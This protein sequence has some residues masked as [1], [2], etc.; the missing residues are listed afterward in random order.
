MNYRSVA[1]LNAEARR[2]AH[3]LPKDIDLV[4]GIPRSGLLAAN[5]L[6][7]HLD[8]P[9]TD[10]DGLVEGRILK[11]GYRFEAG[12]RLADVDRVLV[13]DDSVASG[14][15]MRDTKGRIRDEDLPYDIEYAAIYISPE[16]YQHVDHW[17]AVV[18]RKRVFE[19]NLMHH[20]LLQNFCVDIDGVLCRDPTDEEND[21]G[22][23]YR[24]FVRTVD[25]QVVPSKRIGWLVTSRLEQYREETEAWLAEHG[26]EYDELVMMDHPSA[27]ARREAGDHGQYKAEVY[28]S[29]DANLFVESSHWQSV[30][31]VEETGKPVYCYDTNE[32]LTPDTLAQVEAKSRSYAAKFAAEP[33]GFSI[34]AGRYVA[35]RGWHGLNRLTSERGRGSD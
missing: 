20:P 22:E 31:I 18:E 29:T 17:G 14:R 4:V 33:V 13:I 1:D 12:Q 11:S 21:D 35:Q 6:C 24:E 16:G 32:L 2:L 23:R 27:E 19:W 15:Q 5:L 30:E 26:I 8:R 25:P 34:R 7:L 10:V 28:A 9:M 3:R